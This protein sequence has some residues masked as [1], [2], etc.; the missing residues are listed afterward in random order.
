MADRLPIDYVSPLPPVRSGIAD[1]SRDLLPHLGE[2]CDLRVIRLPGQPLAAELERDWQP[3]PPEDLGR[4]GRLPLY[5]M[6]NNVYHREMLDLALRLPGVV[7]LHDVVLHHLLV[8]DTLAR[9]DSEGYKQ[10]LVADHGWMGRV[11]STARG[12][13]ELGQTALFELPAHRTL[14][15]RQRGVLV[16]SRWAAD[17]VHWDNPEVAVREVPMGV[18]LPKPAAAA[19]RHEW[20]GRLGLAEGEPLL[21]TFGFQTPIKRTDRVLEA[22]TRPELRGAHLVVGGEINPRLRLRDQARELGIEERVHFVGFLD[23]RDFEGAIAACDLCL[24]LRY[25]SAGETSASLLR[26]LAVG[27]PAVVSDYAYS[28]ELPDEV[29]V[30]IPLGG[31]EVEAL[32]AKVG[33]L[34]TDRERLAAMGEASRQY[35]K[36]HHDPGLAA[37][38]VVEACRELAELE[39]LGDKPAVVEPP[40]SLVWRQL[41]GDLEVEGAEP[42]WAEGES[43]RLRLRLANRGLA[44]WL[45]S[46]R[47][48]GGVMIEIHWRQSPSHQATANVWLEQPK[49]L[50]PGEEQ[51]LELDMRRPLGASF[52]YI[53]PHVQ[54]VTGFYGLGGPLWSQSY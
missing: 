34:V 49:D 53:E 11:I 50:E 48:A 51:W 33:G 12:W 17:L 41:E 54:G 3:S 14:V 28:S 16:H 25:P 21:G 1:Y 39:P 15:H 46:G 31:G 27:R 4:D 30:K 19:D 23:Y 52:L 10:R 18:P 8:E 5:Q 26:V 13:T 40:T 29:A 32:A 47:G 42:P 20:R 44:R 22:L 9:Q 7:T 45:A 37:S 6:G 36:S 38:A 2:L 43:R 35:I 24:N